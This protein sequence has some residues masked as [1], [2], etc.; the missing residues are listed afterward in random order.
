MSAPIAGVDWRKSV[1][2]RIRL[3]RQMAGS[4]CGVACLSMV[5]NHHGCH[6]PFEELR[7]RLGAGR[8]GTTARSIAEVA[9]CYGLIA[10]GMKV[11]VSAMSDLKAG[12]LLHWKFNHFVVYERYDNG[13]VTI[14]DPA[15]GRRKIAWVDFSKSFT[16]VALAFEKGPDFKARGRPPALIWKYLHLLPRARALLG[17][18]LV[19]SL[20]LQALG[21][22]LPWYS[23]A[24]L[25]R[26]LP[27]SDLGGLLPL[28]IVAALAFL[29]QF[30]SWLARAQAL[31]YLRAR[32]DASLSV[33]IIDHLIDLPSRYFQERRVG[34]L[35]SRLNSISVVRELLTGAS[36]SAVLD[37]ALV[38]FY[39]AALLLLLRPFALFAVI[40]GAVHAS[41]VW[42]SA[43]RQRE[44]VIE[45]LEA[46]G[47]AHSQL[48]ETIYGMTTLKSC[49]AERA[50]ANTWSEYFSEAVTRSVRRGEVEALFDALA[51]ALRFVTPLALLVLGSY[52]VLSR[53]LSTGSLLKVYA[54]GL[55]FL[56]PLAALAGTVTQWERAGS[57]LERVEDI[58]AAAP[59]KGLRRIRSLPPLAGRIRLESVSFRYSPFQPLVLQDINLDIPAG[60]RVAIVG[61]SGAGKSTLAQILCGLLE[62]TS[63]VVFFDGH[64]TTD[65]NLRSV[66]RHLG[67]V[68][69]EPMIFSGTI[70]ANLE[71]RSPGCGTAE[72]E[73]AARL[74]CIHDEIVAMPM[75][76]STM[77]VD[78]GAAL[79]GGQRQRINLARALVDKPPIL[80]LDEATSALDAITESQVLNNL[81][82]IASTQIFIAHRLSTIR[83]CDLIVV[84]DD[85]R[86]VERGTHEDLLAVE[87]AYARLVQAQLT[88]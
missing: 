25:D 39:L 83:Q 81:T 52:F 77:L 78:R 55:G 40:L 51:S 88:H 66:R 56:A 58:L 7:T 44:L 6:V 38:I 47:T 86:I 10:H 71:L 82:G 36:L 11:E 26:I 75:G 2:R 42:F 4:E 35:M 64:P 22:V 59:E 33:Q 57:M 65:V 54:L 19:A 13:G 79:S 74:A 60:H 70:H 30:L 21:L 15:S 23:A 16:G 76:Y 17:V 73:R 72:I 50:A 62:P 48:A 1:G 24:V 14:L 18:I 12:T 53:G 85:G 61:G 41:V 20:F 31:T 87:G 32:L 29:F 63:G 46:E 28:A 84:M 68:L 3:V 37:A 5:L 9:T 43:R 80:L 34:E 8:D 27:R 69:Q 45:S 49:G 67:V